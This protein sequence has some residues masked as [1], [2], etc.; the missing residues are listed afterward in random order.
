[1]THRMNAKSLLLTGI[2]FLFLSLFLAFPRTVHAEET[3]LTE[4]L[5]TEI[6]SRL[7]QAYNNGE[8]EADLEDLNIIVNMYND[9]FG[10]AYQ[11][12]LD[13]C[14]TFS[15]E[16]CFV[17][18]SHREPYLSP[19]PTTAVTEE[20]NEYGVGPNRLISINLGFDSFYLRPDGYADM[21]FIAKT[22]EKLTMEYDQALSVVSED[23]T[24]VEKALAL[25]DYI[26]AVSNY[27]DVE[28]YDEEGKETYDNE[29]YSAI[30]VF[31][32]HIS[33]C[34]ANATAYCYLLSDCGI[35]CARVDSSEMEHSWAMLRVNG[36]WY[37]ADPTWDN[38]RY[39]DGWTSCGDLNNDIWDLGASGHSYFLKSDDEMIDN[40]QHF[41]WE[42]MVDF[43]EDKSLEEAPES[44]PSHSFEDTFFGGISWS[45]DVH[46][47]YV[48][49]A[50]YF[51]DWMS[52]RIVK[53]A[54]GKDP[55]DA[56]FIDAPSEN[57]MKYVYSAGD[58]LFICEQDGI[59][60]YDTVKEKMEKL[61]LAETV[62]EKG[63][64]VFTEM[65]IA[66]GCLNG[67]MMVTDAQGEPDY[68][69][70]SYPVQDVLDMEIIPV[71]EEETT[72]EA[73]TTEPEETQTGT[74]PVTEGEE[75][76]EEAGTTEPESVN[77]TEA[78][79]QTEPV[80]TETDTAEPVQEGSSGSGALPVIL[81][82]AAVI[83]IAAGAIVFTKKKRN[84]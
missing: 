11:K 59:W 22:Q 41:G 13:L 10:E 30:S 12:I 21:E 2:V 9:R 62:S 78:A 34:V 48:N 66:S 53:T 77:T 35:P 69:I 36:A 72:T 60:R 50:W 76:A 28:G 45:N 8:W 63:Q 5:L 52:N 40:L 42:L 75:T 79:V 67:V 82:A 24:D 18:G 16:H 55:A 70:F 64:P 20:C 73:V 3:E 14:S 51:Y 61:P 7:D 54:Y 71:T 44:G 56:T 57:I 25:Y 6:R 1:M 80:T 43:T 84:G 26:I 65:N 23:M 49:G 81:I 27:P 47:N 15:E 29:S 74:V 37:H 4:E 46:Y 33:V 31:R 17:L 19:T 58:C 38:I 32:D 83:A 68:T 39:M